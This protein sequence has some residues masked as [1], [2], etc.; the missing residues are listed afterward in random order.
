MVLHNTPDFTLLK[1]DIAFNDIIIL[2]LVDESM[3]FFTPRSV[4]FLFSCG[5]FC[6]LYQLC[7]HEQVPAAPQQSSP[8]P[9]RAVPAGTSA[10]W[11]TP[12]LQMAEKCYGNHQNN[13]IVQLR[14]RLC[15]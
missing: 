5:P 2:M 8:A 15:C 11:Q 1:S 3:P 7:N 10:G 14:F 12:D 13:W 9:T 4:V 6:W